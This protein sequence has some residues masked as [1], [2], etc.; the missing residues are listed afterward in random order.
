MARRT[1]APANG[2]PAPRPTEVAAHGGDATRAAWR[3]AVPGDAV[4]SGR[5]LLLTCG[6]VAVI[7][8]WKPDA[9]YIAWSD[10]PRRDLRREYDLMA[11]R[12]AWQ[13]GGPAPEL[14]NH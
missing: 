4:P 10:L 2:S 1:R 11:A 7:G 14:L 5:L 6:G 8:N 9:G 3:Y 12:A 13:P